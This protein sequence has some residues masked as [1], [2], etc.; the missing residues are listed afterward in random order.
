MALNF[1]TIHNLKSPKFVQSFFSHFLDPHINT[2][3]TLG[4]I[5]VDWKKI[6]E[7][8]SNKYFARGRV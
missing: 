4:S 7:R 6:E 5:F 1:L 2:K 8:K 3:P